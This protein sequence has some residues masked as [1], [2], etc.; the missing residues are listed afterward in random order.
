MRPYRG[1]GKAELT[2]TR[3][4]ALFALFFGLASWP[5]MPSYPAGIGHSGVHAMDTTPQMPH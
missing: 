1:R 3:W 2:M 5:M 4:I